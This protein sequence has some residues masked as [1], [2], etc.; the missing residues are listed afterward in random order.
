MFC[1]L[2][3]GEDFT[4]LLASRTFQ[5]GQTATECVPVTIIEDSIPEATETFTLML[6]SDDPEV[7]PSTVSAVG[8]IQDNDGV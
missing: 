4:A 3:A 5:P 8:I 6:S 2:S 7:V 1:F